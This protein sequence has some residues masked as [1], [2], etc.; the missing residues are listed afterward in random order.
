MA[1]YWIGDR[2]EIISS[3]KTGTYEGDINGKAKVKTG[4]KI[5]VVEYENLKILPDDD[6]EMP[7]YQDGNE[8]ETD[9]SGAFVPFDNTLDL[10]I[11]KLNPAMQNERAELILIYQLKRARL[12]IEEAIRR[13][14]LKVVL[15]HGKG[16]GVLKA[17]ITHLVNSYKEVYFTKSINNGGALE[18]MFS[19]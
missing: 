10:H 13:H 18:V 6:D 9:Y 11:E 12:F 19:Y 3:G 4:K 5:L 2:V 14:Q 1:D 7:V 8:D 17:E 16:E 15:I